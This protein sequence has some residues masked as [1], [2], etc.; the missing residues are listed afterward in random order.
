MIKRKEPCMG[1]IDKLAGRLK[2]AAGDLLGDQS[3]RREGLDEER[4]GDAKEQMARDENQAE[5]LHH[6]A[7]SK[8]AHADARA[9]AA[10]ER[11]YE[12]SSAEVARARRQAKAKDVSA[13]RRAEEVEHLERR[14]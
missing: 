9:Q 14:T 11:E 1:V 12:K 4:K 10:A 2:Q 7:D 3:I 13:Q 8:A 5:A 6:Q